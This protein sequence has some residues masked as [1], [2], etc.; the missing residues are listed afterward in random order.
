MSLADL[1][2]CV[3]VGSLAPFL[4]R[5]AAGSLVR[6]NA[7]FG[8]LAAEIGRRFAALDGATERLVDT[9]ARAVACVVRESLGRK[10]RGDRRFGNLVVRCRY[11][12][13]TG[14]GV[15]LLLLGIGFANGR[16]FWFEL[17]FSKKTKADE[18]RLWIMYERAALRDAVESRR[19][20]A[21]GV[22]NSRFGPG[23]RPNAYLNDHGSWGSVN[24]GLLALFHL[25]ACSAV[26]RVVEWFG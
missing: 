7:G 21:E 5:R 17:A 4:D 13:A 22:R 20:I 6:A 1:P 25:C 14:W 8:K 18:T 3:I 24:S 11:E 23:G 2:P 9:L 19:N 12:R 10:R 26:C 16:T 15:D